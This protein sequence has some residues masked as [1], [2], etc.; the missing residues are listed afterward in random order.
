MMK[1]LVQSVLGEPLDVLT[2]IDIDDPS[3]LA[4]GDV[5]IDVILAPVHYGDLQMIRAQ[6]DIPESAGFV[7]RG[8]EAVG[9]IRALGADVESRGKLKVGDRVIGFPASGSWAESVVIPATA[10]VPI[11]PELSDEVAAQLL[12]NYVTARMIIR[13]LRKSIPDHTLRTGAV[14]VTG[15]GTVVAGLLLHFLGNDAIASIGLTRSAAGAKRVAD[16]LAGVPVAATEQPDWKGRIT[17]FAAGKKIVAVLDCVSGD[18][19]GELVP[20]LHDDAAI[21]TYG[22]LGGN[23]LEVSVPELIGHQFIIRGVV[24]VRWFTDLS[25]EERL[26]DIRSAIAMAIEKPSFFRV[27]GTYGLEAFHDA[28]S[29][30]EATKRDGF[31]LF[32]PKTRTRFSEV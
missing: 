15:A 14:L 27:A 2:L 19:L 20:L 25:P 1:A 26:D 29:A 18:L 21:V 10:A 13:G 28:I 32:K 8:S 5:L 12:I 23:V 17:S 3:D 11:P 6:A 7:R 31:V 4:P 9:I 16:E 30:I 24:F 22:G